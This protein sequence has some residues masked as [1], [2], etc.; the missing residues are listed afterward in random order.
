MNVITYSVKL[1]FELNERWKRGKQCCAVLGP[2]EL[3]GQLV[4]DGQPHGPAQI[5]G[6]VDQWTGAVH[7]TS[8]RRL[9]TPGAAH[10]VVRAGRCGGGGG[11]WEG[12]CQLRPNIRRWPELLG[13]QLALDASL[14]LLPDGGGGGVVDVEVGTEGV[15]VVA[16]VLGEV[17]GCGEAQGGHVHHVVVELPG[18]DL[19]GGQD[20]PHARG[21]RGG[22]VEDGTRARGRLG[23]LGG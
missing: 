1:L 8:G 16:L 11:G 17:D 15:D 7:R 12:H 13:G 21:I 19:Q 4:E 2:Q 14:L 23:F 22:E 5:Q 6:G 3:C 18:L 20:G 10:A 9:K